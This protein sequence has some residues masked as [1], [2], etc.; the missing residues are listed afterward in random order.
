MSFW[1]DKRILVTGAG[2]FTG[3]NVC[4]AL[5][6]KGAKVT[7]LI[8]SQPGHVSGI[9]TVQ[10]SVSDSAFV[11]NLVKDIDYIFHVGAKVNVVE[12]RN[13]PYQT[14]D[15]NVNGTVNLLNAANKHKIKR[16]VHISTC[17]I[18]G[19]QPDHLY[20]L[21]EDV[22]PL[23]HDLYAA[24][25]YAA[26]IAL[27][28][29]MLEGMDIIVTRSFNIYGPHQ[30]GDFLV[31]RIIKQ[32]LQGNDIKLGDPS[33]T[34]DYSYITDVVDGYLSA[35]ELGRSGE[36]YHFSSATETTIKEIVEKVLH[37]LDKDVKSVE[38]GKPRPNDMRRSV[39][40]SSK[41][42][43]ELAWKPRISLEEGL[44]MTIDWWRKMSK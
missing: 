41:S 16:F 21:K 7:G 31:A 26:E 2:G 44:K 34:R 39:G 43:K 29:F 36:V 12:A 11:D 35:A 38:W 6:R 42:R 3:T 25:K 32:A 33:S 10:G 37:L 19:N 23:P 15:T 28:P 1:Q 27:R 17:H 24:S 9:T 40:D 8:H 4:D 22:L 14:F 18:Y 13:T 20:P 30:T 5:V